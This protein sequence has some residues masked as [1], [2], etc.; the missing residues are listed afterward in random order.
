MGTGKPDNAIMTIADIATVSSGYHFRG[1]IE[2]KPVGRY[3]VLQARDV[4]EFLHFNP[5]TLA[6]V[7]LDTEADRH[8]VRQGDVLFLSRGEKPWALVVGDAIPT[9]VVVP[10]SFYILRTDAVRVRPEYLAWYLN[11]PKTQ[12]T[13]RV[14]AS[15]SNIPFISMN[16]LRGLPVSV[17][18]L[19]K[20]DR[21]LALTALVRREEEL[22][23]QLVARRAEL[24]DAV[25]MELAHGGP[26]QTKETQ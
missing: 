8:V 3:A 25:C 7:D 1:R 4:D 26:T 17:P 23:R 14:L 9:S 13:L 10:S 19:E 20:Q 16:E 21:I 15:G 6:R 12:A 24:I 18:P 2:H 22:S 11:H 5:A